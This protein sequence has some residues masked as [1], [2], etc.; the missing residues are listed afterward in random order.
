VYSRSVSSLLSECGGCSDRRDC[1]F[2]VYVNNTNTYSD[3]WL[4]LQ[5][6]KDSNLPPNASVK[7]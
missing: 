7:V 4:Y 1:Y 2:H 6:L 3:N 5:E